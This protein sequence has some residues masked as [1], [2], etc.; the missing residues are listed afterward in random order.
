M[1]WTSSAC[2]PPPLPLSRP[3]LGLFGDF[4][5]SQ[6][7]QDRLHHCSFNKISSLPRVKTFPSLCHQTEIILRFSHLP[8]PPTHSTNELLSSLQRLE[9]QT[10]LA[11]QLLE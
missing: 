2:P 3:H 8:L 4:L 1:L 7:Y 6:K 11:S 10:D 5:L 9:T